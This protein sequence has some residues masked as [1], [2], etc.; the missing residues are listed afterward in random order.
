MNKNY[1]YKINKFRN[2]IIV[3]V[4]IILVLF[5]WLFYK[6][7]QS[8]NLKDGE[9]KIFDEKAAHSCFIE[10]VSA[11]IKAG[12]KIDY[13][14]KLKPSESGN[15]YKLILGDLPSGVSG[16]IEKSSELLSDSGISVPLKI[17]SF[18]GS[19][20]GSFTIV[21][22]YEETRMFGENLRNFCRFNLMVR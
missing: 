10:P 5:G 2:I 14:I 3:A 21:V 20:I 8:E 11:A 19:Q 1:K 13:S 9:V 17:T 12:E 18:P 7:Y 4:L 22:I 6:W 15:S 16:K